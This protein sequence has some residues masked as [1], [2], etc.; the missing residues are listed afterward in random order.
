M[1][2]KKEF[3][4][5]KSVEVS[6]VNSYI[7]AM[8]AV[9]STQHAL[10]SRRKMEQALLGKDAS[11]DGIFFAAVK[12]TGIFCRPS[13]PCKKPFLKNVE[14]YASAREALF[15][16]F[17]PC[18]R[19]R[20]MEASGEHPDWVQ[21]LLRH[22]EGNPDLKLKDYDIRKMGIQ[23][24]KARRYFLK[25]FGMTFQAYSRARRLG[26]SFQKIRKG[27]KLDDVILEHGY[28]SHSG[29]R[30]A[31]GKIFGT[32][33]GRSVNSECVITSWI[34]SPLGPLVAGATSKG[35][36]L[37]EFSDRR[38]LEA[39]IKTLKSRFKCA[40]VPGSNEW[41]E[42]MTVELAEYFVGKRR[43]FT[44]PLVYPGAPFEERVWN[45]LLRI[46]YGETRS[47]EALADE[48][49]APKAQRAVGRANGMNRIAILIPCHRVVNKDGKLGGYGGGLW[50]KQRLLDLERGKLDLL[51]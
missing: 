12:T 51:D 32:P 49:G 11:Y 20:P 10:P 26:T 1:R 39:Q 3:R 19:C 18:R 40:I 17:R 37:L 35:I 8:L 21:S 38:M 50:R 29:F 22:I 14:F 34:E 48:I 9:P 44:V 7:D 4:V 15:S 23:P 31:F 45:G 5:Q 16:G 25:N 28:E 46:P 6:D 24:E 27:N 42:K 2:P 33:P 30:D 13:C 36:C 43:Q 41:L 47:Y